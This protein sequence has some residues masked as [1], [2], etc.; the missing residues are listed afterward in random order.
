MKNL[1][2]ILLVCL[3]FLQGTN[4]FNGLVLVILLC[5][6]LIEVFVNKGKLCLPSYFIIAF[7]VYSFFLIIGIFNFH[8]NPLIDVKFQ[9]FSFLLFFWLINNKYKL[10]LLKL[11]FL[12][13][14]IT[15]I[16]Y[17]LLLFDLI[18]NVWHDITFGY[19]GRI[20]G[21]AIIS[22]ILILFYYLVFNQPF[23]KKLILATI[24]GFVYTA[25][26]TNFMNLA[27]LIAL[28]LLVF[29]DFKTFLK[30]VYLLSLLIL[31]IGLGWFLSSSI[32]PELV[33]EKF[34]YV[35][36]PLEYSSLK[37]R[38]EDLKKALANENFG[39]FKQVFGEGFGTHSEIYRYNSRAVSW[40]RIFRFQEIDNGFYYLY[41]RGG[42]AL[43]T[44]FILSHIYLALR[45]NQ[46]KAK[47]G[48]IAI[49]F[50]TN[51]LSIH[52]FN[53]YFYLLIPFFVLYKLKISEKYN[54]GLVL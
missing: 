4:T 22:I 21:P 29:I 54:K 13:N 19:K 26:T 42:W 36:N 50:L 33:L 6:I 53:Y 49:V 15:F 5:L 31:I 10:N 38:S 37:T 16:I 24:L 28:T 2:Q 30:P 47:A 41:H 14:W 35:F 39:V 46:S 7:G 43:L 44:V 20:Y 27:V 52:Y 23:D 8:E 18:P 34:K 11:L 51:A 32:V 12:I 45:I 40:S 9:V 17:I 3:F 1:T 25:M 48:F